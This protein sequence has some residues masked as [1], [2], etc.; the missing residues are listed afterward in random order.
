MEKMADRIKLVREKIENAAIKSGRSAEDITLVA[1]SK[2]NDSD[3][4]IHAKSCGITVFGENKVQELLEKRV[5]NAYDGAQVRLIGHL[6]QNK[7]N[8]IVGNCSLIE[9]VDSYELMKKISDRA[10]SLG[11]C[12]DIL[13]EV[14]IGKEESK[15]GIFPEQLDELCSRAS[16]HKGIYL[17]GIMAIPPAHCENREKFNYFAS[18]NKLYVDIRAKKYDNSDICVLSMGMSSDYEMAI[19]AGSNTVRIGTAIFGPRQ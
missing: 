12:Q 16:Q 1:A 7:V 10:L 18:M 13:I 15:S 2:Q 14:N 8:K 19:A 4:I 9:S 5:Q 11:I 3:K 17:K 6:Q